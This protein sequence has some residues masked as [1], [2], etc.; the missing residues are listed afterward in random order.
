MTTSSLTVKLVAEGST[1]LDRK[2]FRWGLSFAIGDD[3]LFDTF[4]D[5]KIFGHNLKAMNIDGAKI[6]HVVISHD[7]W[8]HLAGLWPFLEEHKNL[9]VYL[10]P[11]FSSQTKTRVASLAGTVIEAAEGLK[12][13][14]DIYTTG[15][16][17][18][19]YEG[20]DIAEQAVVIK[21]EQ[22][23]VVLTGCA[24]PGIVSI[25][26]AVKKHFT[27]PLFLVAGGFHLKGSPE[28]EV[29]K[30]AQLLRSLGVQKVAPLHCT[31]VRAVQLLRETF[32]KNFIHMKEGE[33]IEL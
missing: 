31:G 8:D 28:D 2:R 21:T 16:I 27:E 12:I 15:A 33:E 29:K 10:C 17:R 13:K 30:A 1:A 24:H 7:H 20:K 14:N 5:A 6:R 18:G 25:V 9:T 3:I 11:G 22:G 26:E 4:G 23:L 32:G 19:V